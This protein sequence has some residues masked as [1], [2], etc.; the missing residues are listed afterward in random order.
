MSG[1][2]RL[3]LWPWL[4]VIAIGLVNLFVNATSDILEARS[5]GDTINTAVPFILEATSYVLWIGLAPLIGLA[6]RRVPPRGGNYV[7]FA[8]FH[9]VM[10]V[11]ISLIHVGGMVLLRNVWLGAVGI[12]YDFFGDGV[13]LGFVY[14]WRKDVLSYGLVASTYWAFERFAVSPPIV[15]P[16]ASRIELREGNKAVFLAARDILFVESAGNYVAFHTQQ[17]EH[18]VRGTLAAW[19]ARLGGQG[20]VRVHRSRLVN[21]ARIGA[22]KPRASGDVDITLDDG[23]IITGSRRYRD[24][25]ATSP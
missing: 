14:E 11:V 3:W 20:F 25:L 9:F 18:L 12:R 24:A 19:E 6:I 10:T 13:L 21:Q 22:L 23:R 16:D 2:R 4:A 7:R 5:D 17:M 1:D 15:P 8:L